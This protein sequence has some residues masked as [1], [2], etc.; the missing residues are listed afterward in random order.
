MAGKASG[1]GEIKVLDDSKRLRDVCSVFKSKQE[2]RSCWLSGGV[3]RSSWRRDGSWYDFEVF[4]RNASLCK[5]DDNS[6]RGWSAME[7][8][9]LKCH[10]VGQ[11]GFA[12]Q[13]SGGVKALHEL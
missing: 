8:P 3:C 11:E 2:N 5:I 4:R 10:C 1:L 13:L 7:D 12:L 6:P 9:E